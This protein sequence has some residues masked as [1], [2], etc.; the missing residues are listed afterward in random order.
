MKVLLVT[1]PRYNPL[2]LWPTLS[3]LT[4][5]DIEWQVVSSVNIISDEEATEAF[6]VDLITDIEAKDYDGLLIIS[7][8]DIKEATI[9]RDDESIMHLVEEMNQTGIPIGAIC[10]AVPL[11]RTIAKGKRVST[12]PIMALKTLLEEAGAILQNVSIS[13]D[14]NLITAEHEQAA[15]IWAEQFVKMLKGEPADL[16]LVDSGFEPVGKTERRLHPRLEKLRGT[17]VSGREDR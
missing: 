10:R 12:Y 5:S 13:I 4:K 3:T 9:Y 2:E 6:A 1:P 7:G 14:G 15:H 16:N 8:G 11:V 17:D